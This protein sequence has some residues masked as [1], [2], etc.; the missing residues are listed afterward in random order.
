MVELERQKEELVQE[1]A[2]A[3]ETIRD[4]F[5]VVLQGR[6]EDREQALGLLEQVGKMDLDKEVV[7]D[8]DEDERR[9]LDRAGKVV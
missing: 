3:Y 2:G 1:L 6:I 8:G 5:L 9:K 7:E 4:E